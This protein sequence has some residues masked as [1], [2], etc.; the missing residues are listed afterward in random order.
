MKLVIFGL[1]ISS[2]WGNGHA[3]VWRGLCRELA[4]LGH[5]VVFFEQNVAYYAAHRDFHDIPGGKLILYDCWSNAFSQ[6]LQQ[7][8]DAEVAIVTSYCPDGIAAAE[9][10]LASRPLKVFYDLDTPVTLSQIEAGQNVAYIGAAG[11]RDFDVV[12]S[13]TGG[14]A[15]S[16]L[17]RR[18]G[19]KRAVALYGSVDPDVHRPVAAQESYRADLSYIGTYAEDRQATLNAL[20]LEP[21]RRLSERRFLIAG[22]QYPPAFDWVPNLFFVR[23]IAP[24]DHPALY[25]SSRLTLNVT[26]RAMAQAGYCPSGRLFEA[27]AC[28][29]PI[30]T[31]C[32]DGLESFFQPGEEILVARQTEDVLA[33]LEMSDEQLA[34]MAGRARQ[35][36]IEEHC[37]RRRARQLEA[38]LESVAADEPELLPGAAEDCRIMGGEA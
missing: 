30:V 28:G 11:L 8:A 21:A 13:F 22:A 31:D 29:T 3:T 34:R 27:A 1:T 33:A 36:A 20:F 6:A 17:R 2:S 37:A 32:W 7:L 5:Q 14:S 19:A 25:S 15:L 24:P 38:I 4:R 26:R 18:L 23:H 16:E 10:V 9:L 12:L 35:R